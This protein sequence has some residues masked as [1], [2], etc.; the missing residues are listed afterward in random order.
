MAEP[1][2]PK[3]NPEPEPT[4]DI[5]TPPP[6]NSD[7]GEPTNA[8]GRVETAIAKEESKEKKSKWLDG[9]KSYAWK[10]AKGIGLSVGVLFG[11]A[12]KTFFKTVE[13]SALVLKGMA[14]KPDKPGEWFKYAGEA[15]KKDKKEK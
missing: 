4:L 15:F 12:L 2:G 6:E 5:E 8:E 9:A 13:A 10:G 1:G 14:Q 3:N 11:L 7:Q